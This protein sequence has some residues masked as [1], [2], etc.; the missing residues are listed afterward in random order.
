MR[1]NPDF[2]TR[3]QSRHRWGTV[4]EVSCLGATMFGLVILAVLL[5]GIIL[6]A[7]GWLDFNFLTR[8]HSYI[9]REAGIKAAI[10]GSFWLVLLTAIFS[11]PIGVGAAIYLEEFAPKNRLTAFIQLNLSNL[12]GVPSVVYGIL[13]LTVFARMFDAFQGSKHQ[14]L[15]I[16][17]G[18]TS[19]EIPLPFGS[20]VISGA[21]TLSLLIMPVVIIASQEA[22][23]AVPPSLRHAALALG[24]TEWQTIRQQVLPASLPGIATGTILAL[25]RALGETAP[26]LLVGA[27]AAIWQTPG[28]I[29]SIGDVVMHPSRLLHVPFDDFTCL[30]MQ[31]YVWAATE[32]KTD[33]QHVA[34]AGI[35]VLLVVLLLMNFTAVYIRQRF[36]GKIQW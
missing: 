22:L 24:A 9:P 13:G 17:L 30:P 2:Q 8:F 11:I 27:A 35:V 29:G 16:S 1:G 15:A 5:C 21:L 4:F 36:R 18:V 12:A 7:W 31:I 32:A 26:L 28:D 19:I 25:S 10:W 33:F 34:A 6:E 20:T 3:L 14:V 23:R